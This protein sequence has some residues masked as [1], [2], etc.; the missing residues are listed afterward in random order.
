[1]DL[2]WFLNAIDMIFSTRKLGSEEPTCLDIEEVFLFG[3]IITR[4][5]LIIGLMGIGLVYQA[6]GSQTMVVTWLLNRK[7]DMILEG[8]RKLDIIVECRAGQRE[9]H[10]HL[11]GTRIIIAG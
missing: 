7:L 10:Y 5:L 4:P 3:L 11:R 2:S 1:M 8:S 6:V 9:S